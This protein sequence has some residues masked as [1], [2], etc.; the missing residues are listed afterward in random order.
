M[1]ELDGGGGAGYWRGVAHGLLLALP[2]IALFYRRWKQ[3]EVAAAASAAQNGANGSEDAKSPSLGCD[4]L[5][6]QWRTLNDGLTR[7]FDRL[8][9]TSLSVQNVRCDG[10]L[11]L[12]WT[13]V[14]VVNED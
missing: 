11:V 6:A 14:G 9:M 4:L 1:D 12:H 13:S 5:F 10:D 8:T 7:L 2:L 3:S